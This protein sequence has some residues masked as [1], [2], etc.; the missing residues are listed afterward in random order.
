MNYALREGCDKPVGHRPAQTHTRTLE[1]LPRA[2]TLKR[3]PY[4]G[5][6]IDAIGSA[7]LAGTIASGLGAEAVVGSGSVGWAGV[8]MGAGACMVLGL[9]PLATGVEG[10]GC[11]A[12]LAGVARLALRAL[13]VGAAFGPAVRLL[14]PA[15]GSA[16]MARCVPTDQT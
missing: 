8:L 6:G 3:R 11:A 10:S 13:A 5:S 9:R 2:S 12:G 4:S 7:E 14:W 15:L 1:E 16:A